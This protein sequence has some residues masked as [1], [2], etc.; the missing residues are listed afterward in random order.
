MINRYIVSLLLCFVILS[1]VYKSHI[2]IWVEGLFLVI[3]GALLGIL[4]VTFL[5]CLAIYIIFQTLLSLI[6]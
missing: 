4:I 2:L 6:I 3:L 5:Q 1:N